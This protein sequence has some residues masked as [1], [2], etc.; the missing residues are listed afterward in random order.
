MTTTNRA[1]SLAFVLLFAC[2]PL[3][4]QHVD[5]TANVPERSPT[6]ARTRNL[7]YGMLTPIAGTTQTVDVPA[8]VAPVSGTVQAGEFR[9]DVG[10]LRGVVYNVTTPTQLTAPDA[11]PLGVTSNGAQY[12][13][14]C[15]TTTAACSLTGFNPSAG[16]VTVCRT[17]IF[18][19][20]FP[21]QAWPGGTQMRVYVGGRLTVPPTARAGTYTG[22]ITL[23]IVQVY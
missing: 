8:G 7:R 23:T 4:A 3:A 22:T 14:Y 15:I 9:Y 20:C 11:A 2:T 6:G 21:W 18:G 16:D 5:V 19:A 1:V 17:M 13:G 12:G 10:G